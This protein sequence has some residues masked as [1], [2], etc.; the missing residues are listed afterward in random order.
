MARKEAPARRS[1]SDRPFRSP[2]APAKGGA[3]GPGG[4]GTVPEGRARGGASTR[5][6]GERIPQGGEGKNRT[7]RERERKRPPGSSPGGRFGWLPADSRLRGLRVPRETRRHEIRS[8]PPRE[9]SIERKTD[10]EP[11]FSR[12][13]RWKSGERKRAPCRQG[14]LFGSQSRQRTVRS[15]YSVFVGAF[16]K[17]MRTIPK[18]QAAARM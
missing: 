13:G 16:N 2:Q 11:V 17:N 4:R 12:P 5:P 18:A 14:A 8:A 10:H 6:P 3:G 15:R 1:G 7:G 9:P